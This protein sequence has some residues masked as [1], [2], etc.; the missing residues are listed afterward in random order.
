MTTST[1]CGHYICS[2]C[3]H[4]TLHGTKNW[5]EFVCC[6]GPFDCWAWLHQV[7]ESRVIM[8]WARVLVG[9]NANICRP[10][11]WDHSF[12]WGIL[13][14]FAWEVNAWLPATQSSTGKGTGVGGSRTWS[15]RKFYSM[16]TLQPHPLWR[17][18]CLAVWGGAGNLGFV[19]FLGTP[20]N[21]WVFS[22]VLYLAFHST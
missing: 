9:P 14:L 6:S 16:S 10:L 7:L 1:I 11:L 20:N 17:G 8:Q 15:R 18:N 3:V 13:Q 12:L 22:S 19:C 2:L 21:C 4:Y 5:L